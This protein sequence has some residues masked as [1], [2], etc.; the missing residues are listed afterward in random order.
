M[1]EIKTLATVAVIKKL[2]APRT[3]TEQR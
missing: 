3:S 2:T 1:E